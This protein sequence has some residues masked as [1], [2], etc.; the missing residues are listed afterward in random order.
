D[1]EELQT[2]VENDPEA[3]KEFKRSS[4]EVERDY[5]KGLASQLKNKPT[6]TTLKLF[7]ETREEK[8]ESTVIR[9]EYVDPL[10]H[11]GIVFDDT[12]SD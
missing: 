7:S 9:V 11:D 3:A 2:L 12:E 10:P 5:Y 8:D 6:A 4:A 1:Y